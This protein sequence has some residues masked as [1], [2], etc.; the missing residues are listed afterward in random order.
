M[1]L[2]LGQGGQW[3]KWGNCVWGFGWAKLSYLSGILSLQCPTLGIGKLLEALLC[4]AHLS[5]PGAL[6][7]AGLGWAAPAFSV[8]QKWEVWGHLATGMRA[9][10]ALQGKSFQEMQR[11]RRQGGAEGCARLHLE[12]SSSVKYLHD[13]ILDVLQLHFVRIWGDCWCCGILEAH[14]FKS[15]LLGFCTN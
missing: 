8:D 3:K 2:R 15:E 12:A 6:Q 10:G 13:V 14:W 4:S 11:Q 1:L 5:S 7:E 9:A